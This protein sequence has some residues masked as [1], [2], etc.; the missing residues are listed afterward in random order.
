[1]GTRS[2][3]LL[4]ANREAGRKLLSQSKS[5]KRS[6]VAAGQYYS[7]ISIGRGL[8]KLRAARPQVRPA[9]DKNQFRLPR[10]PAVLK[11]VGELCIVIGSFTQ[12]SPIWSI[13]HLAATF[14]RRNWPKRSLFSD[15][16]Q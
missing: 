8:Q 6:G 10:G 9:P 15:Y 11:T 13:F 1:M 4:I 7:A 16:R 14:W 3:I 12:T 5:P 2:A